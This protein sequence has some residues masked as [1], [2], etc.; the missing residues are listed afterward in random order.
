M[1]EQASTISFYHREHF[2]AAQEGIQQT[3][4][5]EEDEIVVKPFASFTFQPYYVLGTGYSFTDLGFPYT[6]KDKAFENARVSAGLANGIDYTDLVALRPKKHPFNPEMFKKDFWN[7]FQEMWDN[8][9]IL[10]NQKAIQLQ[11]RIEKQGFC[12]TDAI[13]NPVLYEAAEEL[14]NAALSG[15]YIADAV[16]EQISHLSESMVKHRLLK[17]PLFDVIARTP[18]VSLYVSASHYRQSN[19]HL[20]ALMGIDWRSLLSP[21]GFVGPFLT[22]TIAALQGQKLESS[23]ALQRLSQIELPRPIVLKTTL[24]ALESI[25]EHIDPS[26]LFEMSDRDIEKA[27]WAHRLDLVLTGKIAQ[28]SRSWIQSEIQAK[29]EVA[30]KATLADQLF[31]SATVAEEEFPF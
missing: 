17:H 9:S 1:V 21:N 10:A 13:I 5:I 7:K 12:A 24:Y 22:A 4:D 2:E 8:H 25:P 3:D 26:F 15:N 29:F 31:G 30:P 20:Q 19:K 28:A 23:V 11:R 14:V 6:F 27:I 16:L 18:G